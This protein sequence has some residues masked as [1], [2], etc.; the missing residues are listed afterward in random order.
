M[1]AKKKVK[2]Q[3]PLRDQVAELPCGVWGN[4]PTVFRA[5]SSKGTVNKGAGSEASLP[6]AKKPSKYS[7]SNMGGDRRR[8][9][10]GDRKALWNYANDQFDRK[11]NSGYSKK[12][13]FFIP[14]GDF[15]SA[16]ATKGLSDRPLETFGSPLPELTF[17]GAREL[18]PMEATNINS[19]VSGAFSPNTPPFYA[20]FSTVIFPSATF[21]R[22]RSPS[23]ILP[24]SSSSLSVS[25]T[26]R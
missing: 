6:V 26:V 17:I 7:S 16:E 1:A 4:A 20:S 5:L 25:S 10:E 12:L 8:S 13:T 2:G 19:G 11:I 23:A 9:P 18:A 21:S 14:A 15:A 22:T 24:P 3:C